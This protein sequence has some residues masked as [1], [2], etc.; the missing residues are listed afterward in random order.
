MYY[1]GYGI[2]GFVGG[3]VLGIIAFLLFLSFSNWLGIA[4]P[5]GNSGTLLALVVFETG[6]LTVYAVLV[7]RRINDRLSKA[8]ERLPSYRIDLDES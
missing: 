3:L 1:I 7:V 2:C 4:D 8:R 5:A 6:V